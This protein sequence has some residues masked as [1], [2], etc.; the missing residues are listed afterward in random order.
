MA[1]KGYNNWRK[2]FGLDGRAASD[3]VAT[4]DGLDTASFAMPQAH[5]IRRAFEKLNIDGA[6]CIDNAPVV[7]FRS[8]EKL[9]ASGEAELLKLFWNQGVAPI[10]VLIDSE[11][12]RIYSGLVAPHANTQANA[13]RPIDTLARVDSELQRFL[14][15]VESGDFFQKHSKSFDPTKRVDRELLRNLQSARTKL[16]AADG[17]SLEAHIVD[18]LL[19]RLVFTC[20]L[21]DRGVIDRRYLSEY[22]IDDAQ[23][24]TDIL[25][26]KSGAKAKNELYRLFEQLSEDFNG[27]L[28]A[29]DLG[30]E[31]TQ[32]TA[33]HIG[34]VN[35]FFRG[36][37]GSGQLAMW[38]YDFSVIPIETISAIYEHFLKAA[39][40]V[41]K[42]K[43]GAFYTPRFLAEF[44]LDRALVDCD[45]ML[46]KRF[47]DPACGSGIFLVGLF[48]RIAEEW[49]RANPEATY[50]RTASGLLRVLREN[51]FGV[52]RNPTACRITAFSL[53][54]AFLDQL[55]PPDIQ[56][57]QRTK[58]FLPQLVA[59][60]HRP[61]DDIDGNTIR[62][63]DFFALE[64]DS[65]PKVSYVV[66]NP[67]WAS[68]TDREA[69][70]PK[71]I[72]A[73][74]LPFPDRQLANAFMWKAPLHLD[75][76]GRVCFVLPHGILFAHGGRAV[77]FQRTFF[78]T[79]AVDLVINLADYQ[80][81]LFDKSR[82]PALVIRYNKQRPVKS[83]DR[84][85]FMAPKADWSSTRA[86]IISVLAQD[87]SRL[88]L[89]EVLSDLDAKDAPLI[90][91]RH[92]WATPRDWQLLDR[93]LLL[94]RL[95]DIVGRNAASRW[96]IAEGFQPQGPNDNPATAKDLS[97]PTTNFIS[98]SSTALNLFLL[99][100]ECH[101]LSSNVIE[102]R[103]RSNT[104]VAA[105]KGPHVLV[106]HGFSR[107]AFADFDVSFQHALRGIHGPRG[108]AKLLMFLAAYLRSPLARYFLFHTSSNWG[109]SR[110]KVHVEELLRIPFIVP[111]QAR[112]PRR[113]REIVNEVAASILEASKKVSRGLV[114]RG[115][116]VR[117]T[118]EAVEPLIGAYFDIDESERL[119]IADTIQITEPSIRP[120]KAMEDVRT[121]SPSTPEMRDAY[122]MRLCELLNAWAKKEWIVHGRV[123]ADHKTGM[124]IAV[125]EKTGRDEKPKALDLPVETIFRLAKEVQQ[126][127]SIGEGTLQLARGL[128]LFHRNLLLIFKPCGQ[129]FWSQTAALNDADEIAATVFMQSLRRNA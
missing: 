102:V 46:D 7:Y 40:P 22:G 1:Q 120:S 68:V 2:E 61:K 71:W 118:D 52:D 117:K 116:I 15:S 49:R 42:Q 13:P 36:Q 84:I 37:S 82:H 104:Q 123:T 100:Q 38:G 119:L 64:L 12:V 73:R 94:P 95:R 99:E 77:D 85:D 55:S 43:S 128:K 124:C 19:C 75:A 74:S 17:G 14:R 41:E 6:L 10:L 44:V 129:R 76:G 121:V 18:A 79:Y 126:S 27:D 80:F 23:H 98:A 34:I 70:A 53:Y 67:P 115:D 5:V 92:T 4:K 47:L 48:N 96:T 59:N 114:H 60:T 28:F 8:T 32:V 91:K 107:I 29:D 16:A 57:L 11:S 88:T 110:S 113:G 108:D 63:A 31:R 93:L 51:L 101:S 127:A 58:K 122:S 97:L 111:E 35:G 24:L 87:R 50:V 89:G 105:Y 20:Y 30:A 9:D 112:D 62:C 103:G 65:I 125:L 90:W 78:Q 56:R 3:F 72:R 86:E 109:I 83:S 106:A 33:E 54:L 69:P 39:D 45:S 21:F 26:R 25:G 66:G 81:F